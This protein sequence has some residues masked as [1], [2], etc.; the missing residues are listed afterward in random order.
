MFDFMYNMNRNCGFGFGGYNMMGGGFFMM[1]AGIVLIVLVVYLFTKSSSNNSTVK[2][3]SSSAAALSILERR[4]ANG[5]IKEDEFNIMKRNI[6][7][8]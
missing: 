2:N 7:D 1:L 5:E 4:Y 8:K 3:E 6:L